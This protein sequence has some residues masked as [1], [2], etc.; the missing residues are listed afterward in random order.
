M[1]R[2]YPRFPRRRLVN[3]SRDY[4]RRKYNRK[5]TASYLKAKRTVRNRYRKG[6]TEVSGYYGRFNKRGIQASEYKFFDT[7]YNSN[8]NGKIFDS[9]WTNSESLNLVP[10]GTGV[11]QRVGRKFT[12]R[13][14]NIKGTYS[15]RSQLTTVWN[16]PVKLGIMIV[17]DKMNN[18]SSGLTANQ[19][20]ADSTEFESPL[21]MEYT[22]RFRVL[23]RWSCI[24]DPV[25]E[26]YNGSAKETKIGSK[27][28]EINLDN[29]NININMDNGSTISSVQDNNLCI[30][31]YL[32]GPDL[33]QPD[34]PGKLEWYA[35]IRYSDN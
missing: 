13:K 21:N 6:L 11:S 1:P 32:D 7:T 30:L 18:Q 35:R 23:K 19:V 5:M 28:F 33:T 8:D 20:F 3:K 15:G 16:A 12:I 24:I 25:N 34:N 27:R 4:F 2:F 22:R 31:L 26:F 17:H 29:L 9:F 14:L 10:Q